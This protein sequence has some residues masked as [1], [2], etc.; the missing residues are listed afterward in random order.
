MLFCAIVSSGALVACAA[1]LGLEP[2]SDDGGTSEAGEGSSFE[3]I[4]CVFLDAQV[5]DAAAPTTWYPFNNSKDD[6][7]NTLFAFFDLSTLGTPIGNAALGFA[8]GTSDGTNLY[9]AP[10]TN[11]DAGLFLQHAINGQLSSWNAFDFGALGIPKQAYQGAAYDGRYVY[12]AS[13]SVTPSYALRYDTDASFD[14]T[15]AWS[16][17]DV[18]TA[19]QPDAGKTPLGF[20][21]VVF[22]GRYVYFVP[23]NNGT[24]AR[25]DTKPPVSDAGAPDAGDAAVPGAFATSAHWQAFDTS[26]LDNRSTGFQGA[27]FDGH[28]IYLVPYNAVVFE[29]YDTTN[30]MGFGNPSAWSSYEIDTL[31]NAPKTFAGAVYDGHF[32]YLVPHTGHITLRYDSSKGLT[33]S[34]FTELDMSTVLPAY[35]GG[36]I[37]FNAGAFDGRFVYYMPAYDSGHEIVRYDTLS[38]FTAPCAWEALDLSTSNAQLGTYW[39]GIYDGHYLWFVP[40]HSM[41]VRYETKTPAA[42]PALPQWNGSSF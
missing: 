7:G 27:I 23:Y 16:S 13:R 36:A 42:L 31:P 2:P 14:A 4:P 21:G 41:V 30:K 10:T 15:S 37:S 18:D 33:G 19:G 24:I 3:T 25:Y 11:S 34:A 38:P 22:D 12:F 9:F 8:G 26:T 28:F 1:I 40:S 17:F 29:R 5:A 20:S 39:G 32:I 35:D 6:A